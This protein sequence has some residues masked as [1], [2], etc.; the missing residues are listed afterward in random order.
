MFKRASPFDTPSLV[1]EL[2]ARVADARESGHLHPPRVIA[3]CIGVFLEINP[4]Q[5]GN[6][7]LSRVLTTLLLVRAGYA[8]VFCSSFA[9]VIEQS[10]EPY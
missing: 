4:F 5:D 8:Y 10:K 1:T 2:A 3:L 9:G 7:R 6:G